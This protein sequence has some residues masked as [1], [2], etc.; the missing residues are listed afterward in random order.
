MG[1]SI[2]TFL[3]LIFISGSA[4]GQDDLFG[5]EK[6]QAR[7]GMVISINGSFDSPMADM[8]KRFGLSYRIGPSFFYKTRSNWLFGAK[9]DFILGNKVKEDSLLANLGNI[10][11]GYLSGNGFRSSIDLFERG[12][13]VGLQA[14]KII[15]LS[16]KNM[17]NGLMLLTSIGFIQH[18]IFISTKNS[19]S[20]PQL[21]GDYKK[22]YDRLVNGIYLEQFVG[23]TYFA[24]DGLVNF[25]IGLDVMAGFTK[26]RRDYLFDIR[27]PGTDSRLDMLIGIR[28]SWYIPVFKRKS[29]EFYFE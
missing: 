21:E 29:E 17:D 1:R 3:F 12:Y 18:K 10:N 6:K 19:G 25:N 27:K 4:N 22:G 5:N 8:A 26:G 9:A 15:N 11:N 28:G 24:N 13:L 20:M 14:G 16:K 7:K 2:L 23:Y